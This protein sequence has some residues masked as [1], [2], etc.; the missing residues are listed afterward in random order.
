[1]SVS[2]DWLTSKLN[3]SQRNGVEHAGGII[4]HWVG[5]AC[6]VFFLFFFVSVTVCVISLIS[7]SLVMNTFSSL[8]RVDRNGVAPGG[9]E[10]D[11]LL[12]LIRHLR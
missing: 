4:S 10:F 9:C 12:F 8:L 7:L 6:R 5:L 11:Q 3:R 1:M 2:C